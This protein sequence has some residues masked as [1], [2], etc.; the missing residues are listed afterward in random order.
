[1]QFKALFK[2]EILVMLANRLTIF[3]NIVIPIVIIC[4]SLLYSRTSDIYVNIG[5]YGEVGD[6]GLFEEN[7]N[8][9][10]DDATFSVFPYS[11]RQQMEEDFYKKNINLF[12]VGN[13]ENQ[14][15]V[16]YDDTDD[17]SLIA[18]RYFISLLQNLNSQNYSA[19][20]IEQ[21][22]DMQTY[23]ISSTVVKEVDDGNA[24]DSFMWS[25]FVWILIYS[26]FSVAISQM[27]QERNTKTFLY[28]HKL[29]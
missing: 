3:A 13:G 7:L 18:Y 28:L 26:N 15:D 1:M 24:V 29:A 23:V 16:Y 4:I 22:M 9:F 17:K 19:K 11:D 14:F 10:T 12:F 20:M 8:F 27:Q 5:C 21:I 2:K 25:G 6:A